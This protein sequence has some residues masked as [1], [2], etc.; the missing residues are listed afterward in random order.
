MTLLKLIK[1][2]QNL[3][4]SSKSVFLC[5]IFLIPINLCISSVNANIFMEHIKLKITSPFL[6]TKYVD[7]TFCVIKNDNVVCEKEFHKQFNHFAIY[8]FKCTS[9]WSVDSL[10]TNRVT[11][12]TLLDPTSCKQH[13]DV[14]MSSSAFSKHATSELAVFSHSFFFVLIV[15][16]GS[17]EYFFGSCEAAKR[18]LYFT[19]YYHHSKH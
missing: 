16:Q 18:L 14:S 19:F 12:G 15:K 11:N 13:K 17:F 6:L 5:K 9:S 1:S 7:D 10:L 8:L 2:V 3:L 4:L